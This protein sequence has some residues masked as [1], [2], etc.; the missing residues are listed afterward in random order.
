M[1]C[2]NCGWEN[3]S[4]NQKCEKCNAPLKIS[5]EQTDIPII[6]N[7][8]LSATFVGAPADLP[9]LDQ[10]FV[11]HQQNNQTNF[12]NCP[13]CGYPDLPKGTL[14]CPQCHAVIATNIR[15]GNKPSHS[16]TINPYEQAQYGSCFLTPVP[17]EG[18][19]K[20]EKIEFSGD[21]IQVNRKNLDE[22]NM[23]ITGKVQAEIELKNG[24]CFITNKSEMKTTFIQVNEQ[25][26]LKK[27]D[28]ILMGDRKFIIEF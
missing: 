14:K 21:I 12:F 26:E 24:K 10:P 5:L 22:N 25:I 17:R 8:N 23:T 19:T 28:V 7:Q 9:F 4:T 3:P 20:L 11:D 1:R 15:K 6:E 16:A 27:G 18:E 13:E 2:N